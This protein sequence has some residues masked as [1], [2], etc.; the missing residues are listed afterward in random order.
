MFAALQLLDKGVV[1]IIGPQASPI[2]HMISFIATGLQVPLIS[3]A[4]TDPTLSALQFPYFLRAT[5]SDAHQMAA[6]ANLLDYYDWKEI[7]VI[8]VDNDYGRNGVSFLENELA[9]KR[10]RFRFKIGL[11]VGASRNQILNVLGKYYPTEP[12]VYIV[13]ANPDTGLMIF[14]V[15]RQ[16]NMMVKNYVWFASDWLAAALDSASSYDKAI[17]DSLEGVVGFRQHVPASDKMN[18]FLTRWKEKQRKAVVKHDLNAYGLFAYDAVWMVAIAI[19]E[20]LNDGRN[21]SFSLNT[22]LNETGK[23]AIQLERLKVFD[24]GPILLDHLRKTDFD[25]L[26]GRLQFDSERNLINSSYM[27][28]NINNRTFQTIGYWSNYSGL[29]T[30]PPEALRE[31][32]VSYISQNQHLGNVVWPGGNMEKPRG[33]EIANENKPLRIVVPRRTSF[34][35]FVTENNVTHKI[36]GYSIDVFEAALKHISYNIPHK[37]VPFGDG[38]NNPSYDELVRLVSEDVSL[39]NHLH[40]IFQKEKEKS[41]FYLTTMT[42]I[43]L[44]T[45]FIILLGI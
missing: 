24:G 18:N 27:I 38:L 2:A 11:P 32:S 22:K 23:S 16:L 13:H 1:A 17:L 19:N 30:E 6:I 43:L 20:Y 15:A 14:E 42:P 8:F 10:I 21:I 33:W 5:F 25:G 36:E 40:K 45:L 26:T 12:R 37:F 41:F 39:A 3:F 31:K 34:T 29:S 9:E 28:F 7:V 44:M 35:E 4:A